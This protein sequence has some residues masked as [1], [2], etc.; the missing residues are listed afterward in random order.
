MATAAGTLRFTQRLLKS[1]AANR[2]LGDL[3]VT[4]FGVGTYRMGGS[5]NHFEAL[6][7]ALVTGVSNVIDSSSHYKSET[8]IGEVL[9]N[10]L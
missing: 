2:K 9:K 1:A 4:P 5:E 8:G 7:G 3:C 10:V 6:K